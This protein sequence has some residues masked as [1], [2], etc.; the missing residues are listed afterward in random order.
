ME[1]KLPE[2][3]IPIF[4]LNFEKGNELVD[5]LIITKGER[6]PKLG[7]WNKRKAKKAIKYYSKCLSMIPNH[8]QTNWLIA[9]VYQAMSENKKA[10]NHFETAVK[11]E[12]TNPDLPREASIS[13]M[14][15]G[16]VKLAVEY[17][18]EAI[19]RESNDAGLYCNHALNL[20]VLGN[21]DKAKIYID[22]AIKMAPDDEINKNVYALINAVAS[23]ER[24]RPKY[25]ELN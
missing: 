16:N 5:G 12:K 3:K 7:F 2:D 25:N 17:S 9:K 24:K 15:S 14:D 8:W 20:M 1:Y 4:N 19:N 18:Q 21:D 13:A 23:G 10:L 22:R 11:I 6:R